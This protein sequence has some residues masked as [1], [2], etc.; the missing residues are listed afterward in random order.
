MITA[1]S[2][3]HKRALNSLRLMCSPAWG[4]AVIEDDPDVIANAGYVIDMGSGG[5]EQETTGAEEN[6]AGG[7]YKKVFVF[8]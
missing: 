5:G 3:G 8:G 1:S 2:G 4:A 6:R 7:H